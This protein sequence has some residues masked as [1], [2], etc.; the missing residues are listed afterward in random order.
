MHTAS[1]LRSHPLKH[2]LCFAHEAVAGGVFFDVTLVVEGEAH[3]FVVEEADA[4]A[5]AVGVSG[6]L[7]GG[8]GEDRSRHAGHGDCQGFILREPLVYPCG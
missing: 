6:G 1:Y 8:L 4:C 5:E 3:A 7:G 2:E